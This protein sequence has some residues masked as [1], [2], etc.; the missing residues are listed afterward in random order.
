MRSARRYFSPEPLLQ[1]PKYVK[2]MA[3]SGM[4]VP[5][6]AYGLNNPLRYF[7]QDGLEVQN[8]SPTW[9]NRRHES[10]ATASGLIGKSE[11]EIVK[12]FGTPSRLDS[13]PRTYAY[14]PYP[15]VPVSQVKVFVQSGNVTGLK[16]FDD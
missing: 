10:L 4:S 13:Q 9:F 11:D 2:N 16:V 15:F 5:T 6:Y 1:N 3:K 12:L 7:D 8:N 14:Y